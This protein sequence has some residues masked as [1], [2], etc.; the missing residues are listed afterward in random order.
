MN[1]AILQPSYIPWRGYFDQIRRVDLFV[2]FDDVQYD[3]NGWRNR[4]RIKTANG[5]I[6]LTVPVLSKGTTSDQ[7]LIKDIEINWDRQWNEKHLATVRQAYSRAPFFDAYMTLVEGFLRDPPRLLADLT[8]PSTVALAR[9]LGLEAEFL[10]SSELDVSGAKTDR[11]LAILESVSAT[12]YVSGPAARTYLEEDRLE[13]AGISVEYVNYDYA[14]YEQLYPPF[15]PQVS[16]LDLLFM[17][18]PE[19]PKLIR[20]Q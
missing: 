8:I 16:I 19:A 13:A 18:G 15:D 10:R 20:P 11:I 5:S 2:F 7:V 9:E 6:W 4:N 17:A 3:K 14:E 1:C 12:H